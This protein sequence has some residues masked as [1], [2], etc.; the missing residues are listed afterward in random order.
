M[1]DDSIVARMSST[2]DPVL[3]ELPEGRIDPKLR[4]VAFLDGDQPLAYLHF[5]AMHPQS[6]YGDGRVTYDVPGIAR[7]G[8]SRNSRCRRFTFPAAAAI[9]QWASTT[10]AR[11]APGGPLRS[12]VRGHGAIGQEHPPRAGRCD[13]VEGGR[14][15]IAASQWQRLRGSRCPAD[16]RR[17]PDR[18]RFA[19][20][21]GHDP[22][23][24]RA[25]ERRPARPDRLPANGLAADPQPA[26][27]YLRGISALGPADLPGQVRGSR[28]FRRFRHVLSLHRPG[29]HRPGRLRADIQLRRSV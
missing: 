8:W 13:P 27:R 23:L 2:R 15:A 14:R 28:R 5:Y 16:H 26:R 12:A 22:G 17:H 3:R 25:G 4:T 19:D 9:S 6:F 1:P 11:G 21:G 29:L 24:D 10:T 18:R 20:Q 7:N